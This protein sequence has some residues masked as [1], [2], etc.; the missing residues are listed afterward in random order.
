M[1]KRVHALAAALTLMIVASAS[2]AT[3]ERRQAK[4]SGFSIAIPIGVEFYEDKPGN[5]MPRGLG[6]SLIWDD[7]AYDD[8]YT[9]GVNYFHIRGT[10]FHEHDSEVYDETRNRGSASFEFNY[11]RAFTRLSDADDFTLS[12]M[13]KYEYDYNTHQLEE[14]EHLAVTGLVLNRRSGKVNPYDLGLTL[15]LAYSE[16]EKDDDQPRVVQI[17]DRHELNR[18]GFGYFFECSNRYTFTG[19]GLQLSLAYRRYDGLWGYDDSK[20]YAFDRITVGVGMPIADQRIFLHVSGQYSSRHSER[21]LIGFDDNLYHFVA[22]CAYH[23]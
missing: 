8:T 11:Q 22:E 14:F 19:T 15:G 9:L 5:A 6:L 13:A 21:D 16:E 4:L 1:Q 10:L 17:F 2:H 12:Y 23:F 7:R 3:S 20:S 18:S